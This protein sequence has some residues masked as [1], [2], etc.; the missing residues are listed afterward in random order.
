MKNHADTNRQLIDL[1]YAFEEGSELT[2]AV[3]TLLASANVLNGLGMYYEVDVVLV[4]VK[5]LITDYLE[6]EH[7]MGA[8][9]GTIDW[10][11]Y[12][13][14]DARLFTELLGETKLTKEAFHT[15]KAGEEAS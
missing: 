2:D 3:H 4:L 10:T 13:A 8:V 11:T 9:E 1:Y 6:L 5:K 15:L 12:D 14:L 7:F